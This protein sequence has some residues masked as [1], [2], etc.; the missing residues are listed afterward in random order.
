MLADKQF[1][2]IEELKA[3]AQISHAQPDDLIDFY[4]LKSRKGMSQLEL[5]DEVQDDLKCATGEFAKDGDDVNKLSRILQF[6]EF[7]DPVYA[8]A[9]VT[10]HHYDIV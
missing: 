8:E 9:Y 10:V 1:R 5:E 7:S 6:T 4:H 3:K 2:E